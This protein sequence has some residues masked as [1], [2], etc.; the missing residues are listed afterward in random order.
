M[1]AMPRAMQDGPAVPASQDGPAVPKPTGAQSMAGGPAIAIEAPVDAMPRAMQDGPAV[2]MD[3]P[4]AGGSA[5]AM[6]APMEAGPASQDGP[7]VSQPTGAQSMAEGPAI[8]IEAG[9]SSRDGVAGLMVAGSELMAEG[10]RPMAG[11]SA[12][13]MGASMEAGHAGQGGP[14]MPIQEQPTMAPASSAAQR[15]ALKR[16]ASAQD[17]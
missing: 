8:A 14:A 11:G 1:D 13:T 3:D 7:A 15:N 2:P 9:H 5:G 17:R 16:N 6:E 10:P 4:A 12:M